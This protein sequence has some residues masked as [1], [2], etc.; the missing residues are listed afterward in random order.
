MAKIN[1]N[2]QKS[3]K[4]ANICEKSHKKYPPFADF[5]I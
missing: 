4:N 1:Q 2:L 3:P 5:V